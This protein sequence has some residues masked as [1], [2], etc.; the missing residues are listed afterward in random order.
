MKNPMKI[1][2]KSLSLLFSILLSGC[3]ADD[4][5]DIT[6]SYAKDPLLQQGYHLGGVYVLQRDLFAAKGD[7]L[8]YLFVKPGDGVPTVEEWRRGV[9]KP[10]FFKVIAL[11]PAGTKLRVEKIIY[12]K[13]SGSG[14]SHATGMLRADGVDLP[15][16]PFTASNF[17]SVSPY[18]T[19]CQPDEKFLR[20]EPSA[21]ASPAG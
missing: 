8:D 10:Q 18:G 17:L 5:Q 1:Y 15:I 21:N 19:L 3:S 6:T 20:E 7:N 12:L 13:A 11:L 2:G 9:R 14:V 16:N 4:A